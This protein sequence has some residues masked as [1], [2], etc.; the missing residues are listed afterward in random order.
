MDM[1]GCVITQNVKIIRDKMKS[2]KISIKIKSN[3]W[4]RYGRKGKGYAGE[5]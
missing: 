5:T 4:G 3:P 2:Q 1:N